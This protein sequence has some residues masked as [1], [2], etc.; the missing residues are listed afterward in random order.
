VST[1]RSVHSVFFGGQ[2]LAVDPQQ[3]EPALRQLWVEGRQGERAVMRACMANL[4]VYAGTREYADQA[5]EAIAQITATHLV[6]AIVLITDE[7]ASESAVRAWL[8]A[9]CQLPK[10]S[11]LHV[12]CEQVTLEATGE[13]TER[14]PSLVLPLLVADLP[15]VVWWMGDPPFGAPLFEQLIDAADRLV[16][17][18]TSFQ[19]PTFSLTRLAA[20]VRMRSGQLAV[21]DLSWARLAPWQ[22][23]LA[24]AFDSP[25]TLPYLEGLA[26]VTVRYLR[27]EGLGRVDPEMGLL[28]TGWFL[29]RLGWK[30][31]P[32]LS[33]IAPGHFRGRLRRAG[34]EF[35]LEIGPQ[36]VALPLEQMDRSGMLLS[37]ELRASHQGREASFRV[38]RRGED[39]SVIATI[40]ALPD[41]EPLVSTRLRPRRQLADLLCAD[42]ERLDHDYLF[43]AAL[44][45]AAHLSGAVQFLPH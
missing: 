7:A 29:N 11:G 34:R 19:D 14:L 44:E 24:Q 10:S 5:T 42:L 8:S 2:S 6:R 30:Q 15:V 43:E 20:L 4:V 26:R 9:H 17:D 16:V 3:I 1:A 37:I 12:C 21:S 18:T 32:A 39:L 36:D 13:A 25:E 40:I 31:P 45:T 38:E 35:M 28:L 41:I 23:Q 22:D 27:V 33:R